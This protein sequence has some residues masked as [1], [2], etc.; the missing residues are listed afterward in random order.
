MRA[1]V[2]VPCYILPNKDAEL[3]RFTQACFVSLRTHCPDVELV[4]VDNGSPIG[5]DYLEEQ[6]DVYIRNE[7]NLGYAPAVNQGLKAASSEWLIASNNDIV[8]IHDWVGTAKAAWGE[9]T[10]AISSHLHDHDPEH[11]AGRFVAPWG[12]MFGALWMTHRDVLD[13]VG[14]LDEGYERGMFE[15]K[16]LWRTLLKAQY[17]LIKVGWCRHVGNATWGKLPHQKQIYIKN[18][19]RFLS[20][21]GDG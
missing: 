15:D 11:K 8:F 10:G 21:W 2:I 19:D 20:L 18:R 4:V 9:R 12:H 6:A 5:V 16:H 13:D 17:E 3:L 1:S 14:Y 7:E